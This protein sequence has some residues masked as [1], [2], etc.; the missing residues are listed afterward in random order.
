M[1]DPVPLVL[2]RFDRIE[3]QL[4]RL[5]ERFLSL[6]KRLTEQT[7]IQS[8]ILLR[9]EKV[10]MV[11]E[12]ARFAKRLALLLAAAFPTAFAIFKTKGWL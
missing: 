12:D 10:E 2:T 5:D 3:N 7:L 6:E 1:L 8:Q 11:A 4:D 9:L